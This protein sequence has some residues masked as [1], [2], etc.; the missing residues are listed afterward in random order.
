MDLDLPQELSLSIELFLL[1]C[2]M[3]IH[4]PQSAQPCGAVNLPSPIPPLQG[5]TPR[6]DKGVWVLPGCGESRWARSFH[7]GAR[8]EILVFFGA[9]SSCRHKPTACVGNGGG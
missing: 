3:S 9:Q 6:G 1:I 2:G 5:L 8:R 4:P 7:A